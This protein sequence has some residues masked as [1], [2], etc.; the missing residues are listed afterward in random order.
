MVLSVLGFIEVSLHD[1]PAAHG[2]L[3]RLAETAAVA[4][5]GEPGIVR[6]LP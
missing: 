5:I 3:G 6:Y 4:G 1:A 2:H